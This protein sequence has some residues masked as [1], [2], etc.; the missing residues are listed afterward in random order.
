MIDRT[1]K[2]PLHYQMYL[3]L[4]K[5]IQ[6]GALAPGDKL[7][8]EPQ[9]EKIYDVSR[10]TVRRAVE[11]LAQDGLVE[12]HRGKRGTIVSGTKHDYDIA[13][14]TSFTDDAQLYGDRP[15]AE[16]VGFSEVMPAD[17]IAHLLQLDAGETV[18]LIERKRFR[19][20]VI[21]GFHRAYIRR[22]GGLDLSADEFTAD[23]SLY[24]LLKLRG[25]VPGSASEVLEVRE[26]DN[27]VMDELDMPH[28]A[29]VFYKERLTRTASGEPFEYVEMFYNPE[30]YRYKVELVLD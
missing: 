4:L 10:I 7:P 19:T 21:V 16:L 13:K 20:N 3:D 27:D 30:Y 14:L 23:A 12:K 28:G 26:P 2:V 1:I 11:M 24:E 5:R 29:S 17:H 25:I 6:S 22:L 18:Y 9:L 8:P 15:S